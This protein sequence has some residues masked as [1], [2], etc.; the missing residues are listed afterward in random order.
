MSDLDDATRL[1]DIF[2]GDG[3][4]IAVLAMEHA[5]ILQ[6]FAQAVVLSHPAPARRAVA[7]YCPG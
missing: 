4:A 1:S 2:H 3:Q 6:Q 5:S 7:A